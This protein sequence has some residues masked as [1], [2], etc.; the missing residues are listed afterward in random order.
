L[1]NHLL[2][3]RFWKQDSNGIHI[4]VPKTAASFERSFIRAWAINKTGNS[5][6]ILVPLKNGKVI[7][8]ASNLTRADQEA[9]I[10]YFMMV[11]RFRDGDKQNNAPIRIKILTLR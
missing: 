4:S 10:L 11:D 8:D 5:N 2:D 9:M 1:G 6:E 3:N 7:T